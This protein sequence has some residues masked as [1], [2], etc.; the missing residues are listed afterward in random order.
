VVPELTR[1][2]L[3]TLGSGGLFDD[4]V[5]VGTVGAATGFVGFLVAGWYEALM[6]I[7][8]QRPARWNEATLLGTL[9]A[10]MIGACVEALSRIGVPFS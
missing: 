7:R 3:A 10:G 9:I 8:E 6:S 4:I 5:A 1:V 2:A